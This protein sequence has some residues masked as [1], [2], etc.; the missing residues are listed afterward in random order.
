M[1]TYG[2]VAYDAEKRQ[3]A[4]QCEPDATARLKRVFARIASSSFGEHRLGGAGAHR[5]RQLP[6]V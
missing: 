4:I 3:W 2:T 5:I 6:S 1:R